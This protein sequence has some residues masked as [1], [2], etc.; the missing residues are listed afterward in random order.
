MMMAT[1][2]PIECASEYAMLL[3]S[4]DGREVGIT[5]KHSAA[6]LQETENTHCRSAYLAGETVAGCGL[7]RPARHFRSPLQGKEGGRLRA[8]GRESVRSQ[9]LG[10]GDR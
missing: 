1:P 6:S 2:L 9:L 5:W 10:T 3:R 8:G 4:S 7:Q